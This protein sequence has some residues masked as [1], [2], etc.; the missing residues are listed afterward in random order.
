MTDHSTQT[1]T[2]NKPRGMPP[3][4]TLT[5]AAAE[6]VKTLMANA[7]E[8]VIGLRVGVSTKGCSGMSYVFEYATEKKKLEEE[9]VDKGVRIFVD[10]AAVMFLI[11][12]EMDYQEDKLRSGFVFSNPNETGRCG[13]GE[14]FSV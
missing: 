14:S 8:P 12:S 1:Q 4:L 5:D 7:D 9:V 11:G 13:C 10:P 6:R 2:P 3:M